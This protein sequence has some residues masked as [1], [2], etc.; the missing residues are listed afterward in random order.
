MP[1]PSPLVYTCDEAANL[2]RVS[3]ASIYGAISRK[4]LPSFRLGRRVLIPRASLESLL[5]DPPASL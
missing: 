4:E 3:K 2:L 5:L 1:S